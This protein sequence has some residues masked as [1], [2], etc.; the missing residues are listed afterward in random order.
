MQIT[1][2]HDALN[3]I[4]DAQTHTTAILN[5]LDSLAQQGHTAFFISTDDILAPHATDEL[6]TYLEQPDVLQAVMNSDEWQTKPLVFAGYQQG[7]FVADIDFDSDTLMLFADQL[8]SRC[9]F[10]HQQDLTQNVR[11]LSQK[12]AQADS[13]D[14]MLEVAVKGVQHVF[15]YAAAA[16][17]KFEPDDFGVETLIEDPTNVVVGCDIGINDYSFFIKYFNQYAVGIGDLQQD[18]L[19]NDMLRKAMQSSGMEQ[20]IAA[21]MYV[22]GYWI[23]FVT[24]A[25][26]QTA[27]ERQFTETEQNLLVTVA[28]VIGNAYIQ[29][30]R[31]EQEVKPLSASIFRQLVD[32]AN[33]AIDISDPDGNIIYRNERW[34]ALFW[35]KIGEPA[36]YR[37]RLTP[38]EYAILEDVIFEDASRTQGWTNYITLR[39]QDNSEFDAHVNVVALR[40]RNDEIVAYSTITEDVTELHYVMDNLQQQTARL[41]AA[42]SVSQAIIGNRDLEGL[43]KAVLSLIC[44]QF[45]YDT[46]QIQRVS[47][48]SI[49][50]LMAIDDHGKAKHDLI[51]D[52]RAIVDQSITTAVLEKRRSFYINDVDTEERF[53]PS[54][55]VGTIGS[56]LVIP[57]FAA[58]NI[59]GILY[60]QSSRKQAFDPDDVDVL[61]SISDQMAIA[62]HNIELFGALRDRVRDMA[63]MTEVSLLVQSAYDLNALINRIYD[64]VQRV[65]HANNFTFA[66]LDESNRYSQLTR[67]S[68]QGLPTIQTLS[69]NDDKLLFYLIQQRS[70]IF[71]RNDEERN[72]TARFFDLTFSEMPRSFLGLPLIAKDHVLGAIYTFTDQYNGYDENDFQFMLTLANS[73]AFAIENMRLL[74]DT[75]RRVHE[76]HVINNI[77]N[78]L[79]LSFGSADMW[80]T[81]INEL[82]E[83]FSESITTV[84]IYD[85]ERRRLLL[86]DFD[87][88]SMILPPPPQDLSMVIINNGI[89][90]DFEDLHNADERLTSMGIDPE[91]YNMGL[92]RSWLGVP[93][94]NRNNETVGV[95]CLQSDEPH[96]FTDRD[97]GMLQMIAAQVSLALDNARLLKSEQERRRIAS[98]LIEM[99]QVVTSTLDID[100]VYERILEQMK[101][102]VGYNRAAILS[103][104]DPI[105]GVVSLTMIIRAVDGYNKSLKN[106]EYD[107]HEQSPIATV[108]YMRQ[109]II[110][111]HVERRDEWQHINDIFQEPDVQ[112]WLGV[113][114]MTQSGIAGIIVTAR[115]DDLPFTEREAQVVYALARQAAIAVENANLHTRLAANLTSLQNRAKRLASMH[116][117]ATIVSS[118]LTQEDVLREAATLLRDLFSVDH[119]GIIAISQIDGN[120]YLVAEYPMTGE[121]GRLVIVKGSEGDKTLERIMRDGQPLLVNPDNM[122]REFGVNGEARTAFEDT[123]ARST[124]IAPLIAYDTILGSV[125]LDSYDPDREFTTGDRDTFMTIVS[126]IAVAMRNAEL[127]EQAVESNRLKSEFLANVSHE[128]RTPLN[129]IIGYTELLLGGTYGEL[130]VKALD[131][132]E[133]VYRSGRS[134]LE[135]INDIL[136]L[137]KIE[138]GRLELEI[139]QI[140]IGMVLKDALTTVMPDLEARGLQLHQRYDEQL[141]LIPAD[142]QRMRQVFI[143]L[144][145]NAVK[146]TPEGHVRID[147]QAKHRDEISLPSNIRHKS[148][149]WLHI[150]VEDTGIGIASHNLE[151][152]FEAFRQADGSSVR[153]YEGTGLGLAI[154]LKLINMHGGH[155][156]VESAE[157]EGSIFHLLLPTT[158]DSE[159]VEYMV[160]S[161]DERPIV[162]LVDDDEATLRLLKTYLAPL[163]QVVVVYNPN[164]VVEIVERLRPNAVITDVIMPQMDGFELTRRIRSNTK[165]DQIGIVLLSVVDRREEGFRAGADAYLTKPITRIDLLNVVHEVTRM[166]E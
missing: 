33:V 4:R 18:I 107:L 94:R 47:G 60:V 127:Y 57:L 79:S 28:Q 85:R 8:V 158:Q 36:H 116:N 78:T 102:V 89:P 138:A 72:A 140:D 1:F 26:P 74:E 109:P 13:L 152:I 75:N 142:A 42:A 83:L 119:V 99:A 130:T 125:G 123:G 117:I 65:N 150:Q 7:M 88:S 20:Y 129:A 32:Y 146:F 151:I 112:S 111:A 93:L 101:R 95:I 17:S 3:R 155:M 144:L 81:L 66:V 71:W 9:E 159:R 10:L 96:A 137:S 148:M 110:Y 73:A 6:Q 163:Y 49:T 84:G 136:D 132:L 161:D 69:I 15:N 156:W 147:V 29:L 162:V 62:M 11:V 122:D 121:I 50:C 41:A 141:P 105:D 128:L 108:F 113:P 114:M 134:L 53:Q 56:E 164:K 100:D 90:V 139:A 39:R 80:E 2:I 27:D 145:S 124:L 118:S 166:R 67:F 14:N 92:L 24:A 97:T 77:S 154:T 120:G 45:A 35:R 48:T 43:L 44:M 157:G 21:P 5:I 61:Q 103:P 70:P 31:M 22:G 91:N 98:S 19:M 55:L 38:Q 37:D 135:I 16:I 30:R 131:R 25:I 23:G 115:T 104:A 58:D 51:G 12:I 76:M 126:Q 153:E 160:H 149:R 133:R 82:T 46:A 54:E 64:A 165:I 86:P 52:T 63:A 40:D 34:N 59:I 143:N 68:D 87:S 106:Y